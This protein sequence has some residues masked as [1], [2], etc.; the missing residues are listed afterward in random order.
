MSGTYYLYRRLAT[1][2]VIMTIMILLLLSIIG[3]T[4]AAVF[5]D[6]KVD[7]NGITATSRFAG[8]KPIAVPSA[9]QLADE[10]P[11]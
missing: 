9:G 2:K 10:L 8:D 7:K 4:I 5:K 3:A 11:T 6:P 1:D